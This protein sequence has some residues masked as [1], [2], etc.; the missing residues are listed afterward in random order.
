MASKHTIGLMTAAALL[1]G[2]G[3]AQATPRQAARPAP[4]CQQVVDAPGDAQVGGTLNPAAAPQ[5]ASLDILS[6]DVATGSKSVAGVLRLK[7]LTPDPYLVAGATYELRFT[8]AGMTY[9]LFYRTFLGG[10]SEFNYSTDATQGTAA[11]FRETDGSV[12]KA[13]ATVTVLLPRK[14]VAKLSGAKVTNISA[15]TSVGENIPATAATGTSRGNTGAD[16]AERPG[17]SYLDR[18][19]TCVKG[20]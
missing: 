15:Y 5:Y 2:V 1:L 19:P 12:D 13:T 14:S 8:V 4:L 6:V 7:T 17:Y 16:K 10:S 9:H 18:T 20:V 3:S 11:A